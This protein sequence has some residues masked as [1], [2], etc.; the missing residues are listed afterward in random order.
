MLEA[1]SLP[2]RTYMMKHIMPT[3]SQALIEVC[4]VRPE[5]PIDFLVNDSSIHVS[6][7][8]C[9]DM[10]IGGVSVQGKCGK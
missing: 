3:L 1:Q 4:K 8:V 10:N 5:D 9:L 2:L 6:K 7:K